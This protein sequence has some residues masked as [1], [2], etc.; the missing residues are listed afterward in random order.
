MFESCHG[1]AGTADSGLPPGRRD[2]YA[3]TNGVAHDVPMDL[4]GD[5]GR[6]PWE[7]IDSSSSNFQAKV[8]FPS[9]PEKNYI[10]RIIL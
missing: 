10:A 6:P 9:C 4:D 1:C 7:E 8:R 2:A 5:W 3:P